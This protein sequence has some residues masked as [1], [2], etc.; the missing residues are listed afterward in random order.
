MPPS[1]TLSTTSDVNSR[2]FDTSVT[3]NGLRVK[4]VPLGKFH[5]CLSKEIPRNK[6]TSAALTSLHPKIQSFIGI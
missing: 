3:E 1:I 6:N 5:T 2:S 4:P